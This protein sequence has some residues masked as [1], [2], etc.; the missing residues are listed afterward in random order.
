MAGTAP[1]RRPTEQAASLRD[2]PLP[3]LGR[4][5]DLLIAARATQD[6][7]GARLFDHQLDRALGGGE[8][9]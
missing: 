2:R 5:V 6:R 1:V 3:P 9:P 7:Y 8:R 4:L